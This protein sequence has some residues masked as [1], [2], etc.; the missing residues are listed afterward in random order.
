[1]ET[2][3]N[4][5]NL[6]ELVLWRVFGCDAPTGELGRNFSYS[7]KSDEFY[8]EVKCN[9]HVKKTYNQQPLLSDLFF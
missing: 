4:K 5:R 9:I 7:C 6:L 3:L 2:G 1:M 8:R